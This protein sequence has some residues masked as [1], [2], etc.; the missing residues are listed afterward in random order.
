MKKTINVYGQETLVV[1]GWNAM[2]KPIRALNPIR[3]TT[4]ATMTTEM[5]ILETMTILPLSLR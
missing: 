5:T 3:T 2:K 4:P 1:T